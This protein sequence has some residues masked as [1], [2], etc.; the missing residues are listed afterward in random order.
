MSVIPD[1]IFDHIN[2]M[3]ANSFTDA[4]AFGSELAHIKQSS[5]VHLFLNATAALSLSL[6]PLS[7][8]FP[9]VIHFMFV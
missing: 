5:D 4:L 7:S 6:S 2:S 1:S 9:F 8:L 3:V